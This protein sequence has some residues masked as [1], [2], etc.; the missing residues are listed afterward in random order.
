MIDFLNQVRGSN[1]QNKMRDAGMNGSEYVTKGWKAGCS[2]NA[3]II[4]AV[5]LDPFSGAGT[6]FIVARKLGRN[7][8]AIELG[9]HNVELST[10]RKE[11]ELGMFH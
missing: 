9:K 1:K 7:A 10:Q 2:C 8:I 5:V 6:T 11:K 3:K 4:P